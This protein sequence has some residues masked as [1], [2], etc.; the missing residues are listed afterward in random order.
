MLKYGSSTIYDLVNKMQRGALALPSLQRDFV[1]DEARIVTL[2][3]S[4][5]R[6]Y[7]IGTLLFWPVEKNN[8]KNYGFYKFEDNYSAYL[9][10]VGKVQKRQANGRGLINDEYITGVL[11]GQQRLTSLFIG[12]CGSLEVKTKKGGSNQKQENYSRKQLYIDL[13]YSGDKG[14][15]TDEDFAYRFCFLTDDDALDCQKHEA[16]WFKVN[17]ILDGA[18]WDPKNYQ[19]N[20][21]IVNEYVHNAQNKIQ[22]RDNLYK[23]WKLCYK[24]ELSY[25]V[26]NSDNI[27]DVLNI[28][29]RANRG[30]KILTKT[31]LLFTIIAK[32]WKDAKSKF[33]GL[34]GSV[35]SNGF[36]IDNDFLLKVCLFL[37]NDSV[38]LNTSS[39]KKKQV[40]TIKNNWESI[41]VAVKK[42]FETIK[43][44][45]YSE[46][47][48]LS[49]NAVIP[50]IFYYYKRKGKVS[51]KSYPE[52]RKYII[53]AQT[54][55]IF[56]SSTYSVLDRMNKHLREKEIWKKSFVYKSFSD[57]ELGNGRKPFAMDLDFIE[58]LLDCEKGKKSFFLLTSLYNAINSAD[59]WQMDH[60]HPYSAFDKPKLLTGVSKKDI[61]KWKD[62]RNRLP[63]LQL[64]KGQTH[65]AI[66][67]TNQQKSAL[68][69][70]YWLKNHN[71]ADQYDQFLPL[72]SSGKL[73]ED[74]YYALTNFDV[75]YNDRRELLKTRLK[76][77]FKDEF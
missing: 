62:K 28:F 48:I 44:F 18:C 21:L 50:I 57:F 1:W 54:R 9:V 71:S 2:F 63:N 73:K 12:L 30:G 56:K 65:P 38:R 46:R 68:P 23:L 66:G 58:D 77:I 37:T 19:N 32:D 60:M 67:G 59:D 76:K 5:M 52:I 69:L 31:H 15:E 36:N 47:A 22:A 16:C 72:D 35:N 34:C 64:L 61:E 43:A 20:R 7:P 74:S 55:G 40:E 39:F 45:G 29:E 24:T 33:D 53:T 8:I 26:I 25:Y 51:K 14:T 75:F 13:D 6:D 41:Q 70:I 42:T 17:D 49:Y 3:D 27:S 4:L 10:A 11:D